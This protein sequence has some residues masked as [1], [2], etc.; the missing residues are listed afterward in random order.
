M[1]PIQFIIF[2]ATRSMKKILIVSALAFAVFSCNQT[3][4]TKEVKT[5]YVDT[6]KLLKEYTEAKDIEAKYKAKSEEM[7]RELEAE[8]NR[9]K[10]DAASFQKNAQ[11]NGQA[12]AQQ[13]G[14]ELQKENNS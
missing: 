9:F 1:K 10:S 11:A 4:A 13:K 3:Q 14:A 2:N 6:S 12:W 8:V 5:A 7:G